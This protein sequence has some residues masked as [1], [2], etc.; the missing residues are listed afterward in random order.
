MTHYA[1]DT[2]AKRMRITTAA[3]ATDEE[4]LSSEPESDSDVSHDPMVKG[5]GKPKNAR[6]VVKGAGGG[7][8]GKGR[9]GGGVAKGNQ[10]GSKKGKNTK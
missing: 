2:A 9:V 8:K 5:E 3:A 10:V 7:G 1:T 6:N 4:R